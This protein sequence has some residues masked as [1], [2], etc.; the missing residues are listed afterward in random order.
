MSAPEDFAPYRPPWYPHDDD[1]WQIVLVASGDVVTKYA[2][3]A[4]SLP[5]GELKRLIAEAA[6][7]PACECG[8]K[9]GEACPGEP[10]PCSRPTP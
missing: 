8:A 2:E 7:R 1:P 3:W 10:L 5:P 6:T 4:R 9:A